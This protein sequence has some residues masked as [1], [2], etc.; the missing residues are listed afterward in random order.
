MVI[1]TFTVMASKAAEKS[2]VLYAT[3][4]SNEPHLPKAMR[5]EIKL[6]SKNIF[7]NQ[8]FSRFTEKKC[9]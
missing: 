2:L 3:D 1:E 4:L 7:S 6:I 8:Y 9:L 5:K